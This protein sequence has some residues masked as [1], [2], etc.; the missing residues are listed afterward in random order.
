MASFRDKQ[1][2]EWT[3]VVDGYV[4]H[5]ARSHGKIDLGSVFAGLARASELGKEGEGFPLDP[6]ILLELC[7]YGCE[8]NARIRAGK[9]DKEE[10]LRM[11]TG[12]TM[13]DAMQATAEA[14]GECFASPKEPEKE[15]AGE[16]K[17]T[18][19]LVQTANP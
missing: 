10:F 18:D 7:F 17:E 13:T 9:V 19:P 4:L 3:V 11:L 12:K 14:L 15:G 6:A 2:R 1:G 5:R 16:A 8:G